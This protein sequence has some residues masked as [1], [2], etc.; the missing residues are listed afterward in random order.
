MGA[1]VD[2][3]EGNI[4][5]SSEEYRRVV[6]GDICDSRWVRRPSLSVWQVRR[7]VNGKWS[8]PVIVTM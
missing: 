6:E 8:A 2:D 3:L 4:C 5:Q 7:N 1:V